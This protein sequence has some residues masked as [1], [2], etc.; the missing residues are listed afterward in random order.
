MHFTLALTLFRKTLQKKRGFFHNIAAPIKKI[1]IRR[2]GRAP[3][4]PTYR[5]LDKKLE[6]KRGFFHNILAKIKKI[7]IRRLGRAPRNPTYRDLDKKLGKKGL[8]PFFSI[9]TPKKVKALIGMG[10][11]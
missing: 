10:L 11:R 5:D 3:R 2:L 6:K 8:K 1:L 4:N 9:F 7:L